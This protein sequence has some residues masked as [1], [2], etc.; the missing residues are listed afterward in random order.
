M[1]ELLAVVE[2]SPQAAAAHDRS[3]WVGLF[4][5][6]GRVEDPV[7]SRPHVGVTQI[8]RFYDT[9][10]GPRDI[11]FHRDLDIVRDGVVVRDLQLEVAMGPAVTMHIP[12]FLR[13]DLR[14]IA[15]EWK[16]TALRAYWELP[17]MVRQFL[18]NGIA[19]APAAVQLSG[20]LLRNQRLAGTAGFAAGFR[21]AGT[22]H[23]KLLD[24][25][26]GA[27]AR[28]DDVAARRPLTA[29]AAVTLGDHDAASVAELGEQLGGAS[30]S[31][32]IGAGRT[33]VVSLDAGRGR[34][35]LFADL[36]RRGEAITAIRY[37]PR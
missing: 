10:I 32:V 12:A 15:G 23:K 9:F 5:A 22:R 36:T 37:F 27:L 7:G 28:G 20:G 26:L 14:E 18:R 4:A 31:K 3:G 33:V 35:V 2:R 16:L 11:I 25:F 29:D 21:R 6:D 17:A 13:Y 8:G 19:A 1:A 34:G 24:T 30:W